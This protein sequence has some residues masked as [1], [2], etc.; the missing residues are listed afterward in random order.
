MLA[1]TSANA[2]ADHV[3]RLQAAW[4]SH[5]SA[6]TSS[7]HSAIGSDLWQVG[8]AGHGA[9][10]S[11]WSTAI[12]RALHGPSCAGRLP[13]LVR[14]KT[15]DRTFENSCRHRPAA[16]SAASS[17]SDCLPRIQFTLWESGVFALVHG[18]HRPARPP[19]RLPATRS[20]LKPPSRL[21]TWCRSASL[22]RPPCAWRQA[23]A[24]SIP[25][26]RR[27]R[28]H[29]H[30]SWCCLHDLCR[31]DPASCFPMDRADVHAG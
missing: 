29:C 14:P 5:S 7:M 24:A 25:K 16:P 4:R 13:A 30:L 6:L 20:Q 1:L 8:S 9:V 2:T 21:L 26:P 17:P 3:H 27:C 19:Y 31:C 12:A 10:G 22:P 18:A 15:P 28:R 23:I 11:G